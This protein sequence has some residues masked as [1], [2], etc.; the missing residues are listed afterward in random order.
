MDLVRLGL[1]N[2][3]YHL[4]YISML[5]EERNWLAVKHSAWPMSLRRRIFP[6]VIIWVMCLGFIF[7]W[8]K[9]GMFVLSLERVFA[10]C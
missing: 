1:Q 4:E 3:E 2:I 5:I 10:R 8:Q 6:C 9:I 7:P